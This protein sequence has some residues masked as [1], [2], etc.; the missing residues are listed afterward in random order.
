[1]RLLWR[2]FYDLR[3]VQWK[4]LMLRTSCPNLSDGR[5]CSCGKFLMRMARKWIG[6]KSLLV[7]KFRKLCFRLRTRK[8]ESSGNYPYAFECIH[9]CKTQGD[10]SSP[11]SSRKIRSEHR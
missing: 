6:Q 5:E 2:R 9:T 4:W 3:M 10:S 7:G 8:R 11:S 1:M